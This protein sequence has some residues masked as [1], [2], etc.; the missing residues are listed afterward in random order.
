MKSLLCTFQELTCQSGS[1]GGTVTS[2]SSSSGFSVDA[3]WVSVGESLE[4]QMEKIFMKWISADGLRGAAFFTGKQNLQS[5]SRWL[6]VASQITFLLF[7]ESFQSE[8]ENS[9]MTPR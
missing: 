1:V 7:V 3:V 8:R 2:S 4:Q 5:S 6:N 9:V